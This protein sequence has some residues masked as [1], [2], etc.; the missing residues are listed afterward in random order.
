[1][2]H[3]T[4]V[5][6]VVLVA[7]CF[8]GAPAKKPDF[9]AYN[10]DG[11]VKLHGVYQTDAQGRVTRYTMY[12][13]AGHLQSIEIPYYAPDNRIIRADHLNAD[14]QLEFVVIYF[15]DFALRLDARGQVIDKQGFSQKEF[16]ASLPKP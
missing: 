11:S 4:S 10:P 14:G 8:A 2:K 15:D 1:M 12:D 7:A 5:L 13:G 3:L 6:L 9:F 16:L